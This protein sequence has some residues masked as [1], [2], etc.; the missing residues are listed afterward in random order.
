VVSLFSNDTGLIVSAEFTVDPSRNRSWIVIIAKSTASFASLASIRS[1]RPSKSL[2][3]GSIYLDKDV[4]HAPFGSL[5]MNILYQL[6]TNTLID[7]E[8][9]GL[10]NHG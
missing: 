3:P 1:L 6:F 5:T 2:Y 8:M 9:D 4:F 7:S 10:E